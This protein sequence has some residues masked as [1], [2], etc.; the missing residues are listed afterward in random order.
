[1]HKPDAPEESACDLHVVH[2]EAIEC[3][4]VL[5]L[6]PHVEPALDQSLEADGDAERQSKPDET[7]LHD[8][9]EVVT[10]LCKH[11][12]QQK[13]GGNRTFDASQQHE[14]ERP[15]GLNLCIL[16]GRLIEALA[17]QALIA[18]VL[19]VRDLGVE[20]A[21]EEDALEPQPDP[22]NVDFF[23]GAQEGAHRLDAV[24]GDGRPG[25]REVA[26]L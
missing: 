1:M 18:D 25:C 3:V 23:S 21:A 24:V 8:C 4:L 14:D 2:P 12:Q 13:R 5:S 6:Q 10:G 15:D 26:N 22:E 16:S 17:G 11:A 7:L 20:R 9:I 19:V